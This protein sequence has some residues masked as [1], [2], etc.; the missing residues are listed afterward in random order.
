MEVN[1]AYYREI[2]LHAES[3]QERVMQALIDLVGT[4]RY[5]DPCLPRRLPYRLIDRL[6]PPLGEHRRM[7]FYEPASLPLE[8]AV[9]RRL[10]TAPGQVVHMLQGEPHFNYTA[11]LRH[12]P[13]R[14]GALV[15][16]FQQP[17]E[18][19][20]EVWRFRNKRAR[21]AA[22]DHIVV[23]STPQLEYFRE[24]V[25]ERVTKVPLG[26]NRWAFMPP[27]LERPARHE[28]RCLAVGSHLRDPELLRRAIGL[29]TE[30]DDNVSFTVISS[31]EFLAELGSPPRTTRLEGLSD[32]VLM[33]AYHD[34]DL[35][36]H[37]VAH[38]A[39][40]TALLEAMSCGLPVVAPDVG[41]V[42]DYVD[43]SCAEIVAPGDPRAMAE[44]ILRL[45][46]DRARRLG[47]GESA[48]RRSA[49]R[50]WQHVA[51]ELVAVYAKAL[52][53]RA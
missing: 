46:G 17:P 49:A 10:V 41:G 29:V 1:L 38:A 32:E 52:A 23:T 6:A 40:N 4:V 16:T 43:E 8:Y 44:A 11:W 25:G 15:V 7:S 3:G 37:P 34:A 36:V 33:A 47:M 9:M 27:R 39:G 5:L 2:H 20:E 22:I 30:R 26:A 48:E 50:D 24:L 53:R 31:R 13:R 19:F 21:L 51:D 12:W 28:V 14:R 42:R 45:A 35:F 18:R